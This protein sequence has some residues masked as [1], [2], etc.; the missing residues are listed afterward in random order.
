MLATCRAA[1]E[2][3]SARADGDL[4]VYLDAALRALASGFVDPD[5]RQ[6]GTQP[7]HH[8]RTDTD[9]RSSAFCHTV[10]GADRTGY[11][12]RSRWSTAV[13]DSGVAGSSPATSA[14][15]HMPSS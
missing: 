12:R 2:R 10:S 3:W 14:V 15:G 4:T 5:G 13:V 11:D 7:I 6:L 1:Y 8:A 9:D